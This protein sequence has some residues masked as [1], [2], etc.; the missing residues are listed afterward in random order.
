MCHLSCPSFAVMGI[1]CGVGTASLQKYSMQ[2][3]DFMVAANILLSGN[4]FAKMALL[5]RYI[6]SV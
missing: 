4:N 2:G 6:K 1:S 5:F 3:G